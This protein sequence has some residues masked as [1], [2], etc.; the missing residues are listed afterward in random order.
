[1]P[2]FH[3]GKHQRFVGQHGKEAVGVP[4][5]R[6]LRK[7]GGQFHHEMRLVGAVGGRKT[8]HFRNNALGLIPDQAVMQRRDVGFEVAGSKLLPAF[9]L[10]PPHF[11]QVFRL[12]GFCLIPQERPQLGV[13]PSVKIQAGGLF[14]V[15]LLIVQ[16]DGVGMDPA[17]LS[18]ENL[19][20]HSG[21]HYGLSN[22]RTRLWLFYE[23]N[24]ELSC[25]SAPG[26]G[27]KIT[28]RFPKKSDVEDTDE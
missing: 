6:D 8:F 26:L 22:V 25:S 18:E 19:S 7:I 12:I 16:D 5:G 21:K 27:T 11:P 17:L 2:V 13:R 14:P 1:M 3:A 20:E 15:A 10:L 28:L 4:A 9:L 23:K 24:A